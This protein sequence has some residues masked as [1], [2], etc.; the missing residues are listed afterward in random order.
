MSVLCKVITHARACC[1]CGIFD[2]TG[3]GSLNAIDAPRMFES[4]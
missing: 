3:A 4:A 1:V 2:A